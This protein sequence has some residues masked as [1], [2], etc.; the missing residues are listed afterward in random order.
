MSALSI[1]LTALQAAQVGLSTTGHNIA[2]VNTIGYRRQ[3]LIQ[4]TNDPVGSGNGYIGQGVNVTTIRRFYDDFLE[5]QISQNE[6]QLSYFD[7]YLQGLQQINNVMGDRSVGLSDA[8]QKFFKSWNDLS[9]N[10][11]SVPARQA[12]LGA[13]N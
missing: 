5:R 3:Q 11:A 10:P 6:S 1:G 7:Q 4:A 8:I 2:N 9:G 13:A 12:V